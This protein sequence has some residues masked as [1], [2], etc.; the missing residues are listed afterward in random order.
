MDYPKDYAIGN[1]EI[2]NNTAFIIM[3]INSK[4]DLPFGL[5]KKV[6][7]NLT[8]KL[9][10]AD[11]I[12]QQNFI[13]TNILENIAKSEIIIADIT[14]SNPNVFYELG[15]AHTLKSRNS[16][17]ILTQDKDIPKTTPFDI[18]H[19]SILQYD[20]D[21]T[22]LFMS[23]LKEKINECRNTIDTEDFI[24]KILIG[25]TFEKRA[26]YEFIQTA[27]SMGSKKLDLIGLIISETVSLQICDR[28]KILDLNIF[29]TTIGDYN[30]GEYSKIS[31][32]L[33]Y[34]IF[35]SNFVI[36]HYID[37]ISS[38][39][40]KKWQRDYLKLNDMDYWEFIANLCFKLIEQNYLY[41]NEAIKWLTNY[42]RN[43]RMGRID[44]VRTQIE[45]FMLTV[46]DK[47]IDNAVVKLLTG[48]SRTAKES[49]IDICGQKPIF[50]SI[51]DLINIIKSNEADPHI[52]RSSINALAR[53]NVTTAAPEILKWMR[54]NRDKWGEQAVSSS[55]MTV[56]ERGLQS[57]DVE[58]YKELLIMKRNNNF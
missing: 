43:S 31:W 44:R 17:I 40:F 8:I 30:N 15:I 12:S 13:I 35:T 34:L 47:E 21:N 16:V 3:P 41:K 33:K 14:D 32:L 4:F 20:C 50:E 5:I 18:R 48:Q 1:Y 29:L 39:F 56:A 42:L 9:Q 53:M 7:N 10:R 25:H 51:N 49:A 46:K 54:E 28:N 52:V 24:T 45:D 26:I 11:E 55:L 37:T 23:S 38:L 27:R 22:S 58:A 2:N 36:S 57:L 6:C 19:W